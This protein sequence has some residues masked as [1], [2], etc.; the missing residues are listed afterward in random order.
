LDGKLLECG[1]A[2]FSL[3]KTSEK[4]DYGEIPELKDRY[5]AIQSAIKEN[6]AKEA[7]EALTAFRLATIASPDLITSDADRLVEKATQKV[8]KAFPPGSVAVHYSHGRVETLSE[9]GLYD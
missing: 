8:D 5:T 6:K 2:V 1:Y 7:R 9:I 3:R 4:S